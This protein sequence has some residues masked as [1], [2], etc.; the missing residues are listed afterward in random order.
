MTVTIG[1]AAWVPA[2]AKPDPLDLPCL[3]RVKARAVAAGRGRVT[4]AAAAPDLLWLARRFALGADAGRRGAGGPVARVTRAWRRA[5]VR[6]ER[7]VAADRAGR[8]WHEVVVGQLPPSDQVVVITLA[9]GSTW[10]LPLR[11]VFELTV[12]YYAHHGWGPDEEDLGDDLAGVVEANA[13]WGAEVLECYWEDLR[14]HASHAGGPRTELPDDRIW[15]VAE[16]GGSVEVL[17]TLTAAEQYGRLHHWRDA[18][19][20]PPS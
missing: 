8:G 3:A 19:E 18:T 20:L 11:P 12:A 14:D 13:D 1:G 2:L 16:Q 4:L 7:A 10:V 15:A 17:A 9:D 5:A 6:I